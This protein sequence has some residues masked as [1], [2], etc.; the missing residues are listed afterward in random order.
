MRYISALVLVLAGSLFTYWAF[1][2]TFVWNSGTVLE[3]AFVSAFGWLM[4]HDLWQRLA[5]RTGWRTSEARRRGN[6]RRLAV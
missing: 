2:A 5:S 3:W 6:T 1:V 4:C